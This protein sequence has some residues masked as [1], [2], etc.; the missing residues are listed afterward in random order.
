MA[1]RICSCIAALLLLW[2]VYQT[3]TAVWEK[4]ISLGKTID[5]KVMT[6]V[7]SILNRY[8]KQCVSQPEAEVI[9]RDERIAASYLYPEVSVLEVN[10]EYVLRLFDQNGQEV[11]IL[12]YPKKPSVERV[13]GTTYLYE[14]SITTGNPAR[15]TFYFD[16]IEGILSDTYFNST[17]MDYFDWSRFVLYYDEENREAVLTELFGE[18]EWRIERDFS[19]YIN[20]IIEAGFD[21]EK[22]L[23]LTY[24]QG[25]EGEEVTETIP[26]TDNKPI[27]IY[28]ETPYVLQPELGEFFIGYDL[29]YEGDWGTFGEESPNAVDFGFKD[30]HWMGCNDH[31]AVTWSEWGFSASSELESDGGRYSAS[32]LDY[33][34]GKNRVWA[35]GVEGPGIGE[36]ITFRQWYLYGKSDWRYGMEHEPSNGWKPFIYDGYLHFTQLCIVNGY[37]KSERLW[38]ENGRVKRLLMLVEGEPYAYLELADTIKPQYFTLPEDSRF[39]IRMWY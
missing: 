10:G 4:E 32:N 16:S 29:G 9:K 5:I 26:L 13:E 3:E 15:Y 21:W 12:E 36:R 33:L 37:A 35:E 24:Y 18:N 11:S 6:K 1:K 25:E 14:I 34:T 27:V 20:P 8:H 28:G 39:W 31:C 7:S 38:E 22:K 19:P 30:W 2:G 17:F 23:V